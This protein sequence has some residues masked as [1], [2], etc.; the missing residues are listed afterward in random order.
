M[1]TAPVKASGVVAV[2][3]DCVFD[4]CDL[5]QKASLFDMHLKYAEVMDV[6][7]ACGHIR[8][9]AAGRH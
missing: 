1:P 5:I 6:A 8:A 2:V 9:S 7:A 4:R 3:A